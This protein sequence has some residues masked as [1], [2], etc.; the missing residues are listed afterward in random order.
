[1]GQPDEKQLARLKKIFK[2][3]VDQLIQITHPQ[4]SFLID[5]Q[6]K[7]IV[8][9][10]FLWFLNDERSCYDLRKGILIKGDAGTGKTTLVKAFRK[11]FNYFNQGFAYDTSTCITMQYARTG[12]MDKWL[13]PRIVAIDEIGQ[14][15]NASYYGNQLNVI[16]YLLHQRYNLWQNTGICTIATTNLDSDQLEACYGYL[17]RDR[18]REMFNH[19][20][21]PGRSRRK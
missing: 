14:E 2:L 10:M 11:F 15:N 17:I 19:V 3:C 13:V 18:M 16:S 8:K 20:A 7:E 12:N 5:E 4:E 21:M 9:G 6:N 1:M